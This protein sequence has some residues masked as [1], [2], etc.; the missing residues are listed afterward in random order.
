M[1]SLKNLETLQ[2]KIDNGYM[3]F[4]KE[5]GSFY[6]VESVE[7][8]K[9]YLDTFETLESENTEFLFFKYHSHEEFSTDVREI[10]KDLKRYKKY[11]DAYENL[12]DNT[13]TLNL[14]IDECG[15]LVR[16]DLVEEDDMYGIYE[17]QKIIENCE[18]VTYK[19]ITLT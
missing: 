17:L 10:L 7:D 18:M 15:E 4:A 11:Y 14:V 1:T 16:F 3:V 13:K 19:R 9:I 6:R 8:G 5:S 12:N 2:N